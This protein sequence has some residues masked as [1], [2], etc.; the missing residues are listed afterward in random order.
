[1][2]SVPIILLLFLVSACDLFTARSPEQPD[3]PAN[4]NVPATSPDILFQNL[5][6][7]IE[8]KVL[9]NY[10]V[11]FV[12]SSFLKKK[13]KF[14]AASG[15]MSQYPTLSNWT[16]ES[17]RQYFKW[18]K[19]IA[20]AGNSITLTL[21]NAFNTQFGDSAV[22]QFDYDLSLK[23]NDQTISGD[24]IGTAQ[25]KIFLDSRNQWVIVQ[26]EDLRKSSGQ[27]WSDL[28]GRSY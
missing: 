19:A 23:A 8:Q 13:F 6:S 5:K 11:C 1:M 2:K 22:Y 20:Q 15:S 14:I 4:S 7:S 18:Q 16:L 25:F 24:Y 17:E 26:W 12:D 27:T 21:S 9:D 28:K 3:T 10:M